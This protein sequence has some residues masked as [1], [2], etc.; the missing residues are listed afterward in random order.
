MAN[1]IEQIY[2]NETTY[3]IAS[4]A[5]V[6]CNSGASTVKKT[7]D[8]AG[9]HLTKGVTVH[10]K[11]LHNN[12]ATD[13]SLNINGT[14]DVLIKQFGT[15]AAA[16]TDETSGWKA[17]AVVSLTYDGAN[18]IRDQGYNTNTTYSIKDTY[19]GTD[20]NPISGK[21]VKAA[22]E[23]LDVTNITANLSASKTITALS[24]A[25]GKIAAT[26][27]SIQIDESQVTNLTTDLAAKAPTNSPTFTGTVTLPGAPTE[28]LHAA[29]KKYVDEQVR[30]L[31]GAMHFIGTATQEIT[32]GGTQHPTTAN[33]TYSGTAGDVVLYSGKEFVWTGTAWELLGDE[34]S[35]AIDSNV[36]HKSDY[37]G[38]GTILYGTGT[39]TYDALAANTTTTKKVFIMASSI[40]SWATLGISAGTGSFPT[41]SAT[42]TTEF[43]TASNAALTTGTAYSIP[44][45]TRMT[46]AA[47]DGN[48]VLVITN[49]TMGDNITVQN[50]TGIDKTKK[51]AAATAVSLSGGSW[52]TPSLTYN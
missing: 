49:G 23:T 42:I 24:E 20:G 44:N 34:G 40:P 36:V 3:N 28:D 33:G 37:S 35:Y 13:P 2:L 5:Y 30:G 26:A 41:L 11:F 51:A 4:T 1:I 10:V 8:L 17:G 48:A 22:L 43:L 6:E 25:D 29:T 14:G 32:D 38:K 12:T 52:P 19:S 21:G 18:W 27:S 39:G 16:G 46:S 45:V 47:V 15:T 9:F 7:A 31:T 50:I